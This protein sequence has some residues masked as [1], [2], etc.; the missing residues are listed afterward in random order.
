MN[1]MSALKTKQYFIFT[2]KKSVYSLYIYFLR[3]QKKEIKF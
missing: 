3:V 2:K 1:T